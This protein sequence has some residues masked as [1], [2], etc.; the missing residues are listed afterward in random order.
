MNSPAAI[1]RWL[2]TLINM[3]ARILLLVTFQS[4]NGLRQRLPAL[5]TCTFEFQALASCA[6]EFEDR[7]I[8]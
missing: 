1:I 6:C 2:Q 3:A 4:Y 5:G 8:N 7:H